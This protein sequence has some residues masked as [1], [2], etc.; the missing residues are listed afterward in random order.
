MSGAEW[1]VLLLGVATIAWL[2][3]YFFV[4]SRSGGVSV[5]T[6]GNAG[7]IVIAVHGG[8][9]PSV[10]RAKVGQPLRLTCDRVETNTCSEEIVIPEFGIRTFLPPFKQTTVEITPKAPGK[11][12]MTCGM[13]MLHGTIIAE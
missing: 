4:A 9:S 8:Y 1:V 3:L 5:A 6:E 13:S 10:I 11:F 12:E 7:H 2:N